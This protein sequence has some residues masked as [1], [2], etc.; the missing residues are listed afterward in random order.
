MTPSSR[1]WRWQSLTDLPRVAWRLTV[2]MAGMR[3]GDDASGWLPPRG[4][5]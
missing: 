1:R 3:R 4:E 5:R 2:V